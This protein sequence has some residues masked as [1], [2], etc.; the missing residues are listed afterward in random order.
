MSDFF[1][2]RGDFTVTD[3]QGNTT[4]LS[5]YN[6]SI[7]P[8]RF[9]SR[10]LSY[11]GEKTKI[12]WDFGDG[13]TSE[14]K[15]PIYYYRSPGIYRAKLIYYNCLNNGVIGEVYKDIIIKD[16]IVDTF[17]ITTTAE[18]ISSSS[19]G[20]SVPI[21]VRQTIPYTSQSNTIVYSVS[22]SNTPW[23]FKKEYKY[24][25]LLPHHSLY[26]ILSTKNIEVLAPVK[27]LKIA[28][29]RMYG[30]LQ[31]G[32]IIVS[33]TRSRSSILLGYSGTQTVFYKDDSLN[34]NFSL[35][36][37]REI[38]NSS[39]TVKTTLTGIVFENQN[40]SHLSITSTGIDGDSF[41]LDTF[42]ISPIK[43]EGAKI[44]FVVKVKDIYNNTVKNFNTPISIND[45][46][47]HVDGEAITNYHIT[48]LQDTI[49]SVNGEMCAFRGC[50]EF[51]SI[52]SPL[53]GV[54]VYA[55]IQATNNNSTDFGTISG[56]SSLFTVYPKNYYTLNKINE[57]YDMGA[58]LR[59]LGIAE[60]LIDKDVFFENFLG[61]IFGNDTVDIN[62]LGKKIYER[63]SNFTDN[64]NSIDTA[65]VFQLESIGK[66]ID[67]ELNIFDGTIVSYP[68]QIKRLINLFSIN[69][70]KLF[71]TENKFIQNFD[72]ADEPG[73]GKYGI[74]LG[75]QISIDN[76]ITFPLTSKYIVAYEK[77]SRKYTLLN[78]FQP[79]RG[80]GGINNIPL[81]SH[82]DIN[83]TTESGE[84]IF[85]EGVYY[86][87]NYN[88]TWG[89]PLVLPRDFMSTDLEK[90]YTFYHFND[91]IAGNAIGGVIDV[92]ISSVKANTTYNDLYRVG[93]IYENILL[94]TLYLSLSITK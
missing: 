24:S 65:E 54:Q 52:I 86:I 61:V 92:N 85:T 84:E 80:T 20:L 14:V 43:F 11:V 12:V 93:G 3:Y 89:W 58:A 9:A 16:F 8:L 63:I 41:P 77:F 73:T 71:G 2:N 53:T 81:M 56:A 36:F 25:H 42:N 13:N 47:I 49:T 30:S 79:L 10:S 18:T 4:T 94:N 67:V 60:P 72:D 83:I 44:P 40:V 51:D 5:S 28:A 74:N 15:E 55:Q 22:G 34:N 82:N 76:Y 57:N 33:P 46:Y 26:V 91:Q 69:K 45:I 31:D 88:K 35:T 32:E 29:D 7:T 90:Y 19:G 59:S 78:T 39:N 37:N 68:S 87:N 1:N 17:N 62:G 50:V 21:T 48:T 6:L 75:S 27:S 23:Y 64:I 38:A 70:H 66:M